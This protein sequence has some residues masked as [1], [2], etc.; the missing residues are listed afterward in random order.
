MR[1]PTSAVLPSSRHPM[2]NLQVAS[3]VH[4]GPGDIGFSVNWAVGGSETSSHELRNIVKGIHY[5]L[6]NV[7]IVLQDMESEKFRKVCTTYGRHK[8]GDASAFWSL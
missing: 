1:S 2:L 8:P 3:H 4:I 6:V 7:K 5:Y